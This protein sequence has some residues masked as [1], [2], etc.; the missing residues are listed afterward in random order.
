MAKYALIFHGGTVPE[1]REEGSLD[2]A[3]A[4]ATDCPILSGGSSIEVAQVR[5]NPHPL[6][7]SR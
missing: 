4:L 6:K 5:E 3:V 1:T 7:S 2:V